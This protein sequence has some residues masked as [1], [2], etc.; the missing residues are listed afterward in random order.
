MN[1]QQKGRF[2]EQGLALLKAI[3]ALL[4]NIET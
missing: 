3:V 4:V 2:G 1:S